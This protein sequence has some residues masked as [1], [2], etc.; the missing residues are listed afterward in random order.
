MGLCVTRRFQMG[1]KARNLYKLVVGSEEGFR[2]EE[3]AQRSGTL[4][5]RPKPKVKSIVSCVQCF[6]ILPPLFL[7]L[8]P[9][10]LTKAG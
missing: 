8:H 2:W 3:E 6:Y 7:P 10:L 4:G 5:P 1:P 9:L